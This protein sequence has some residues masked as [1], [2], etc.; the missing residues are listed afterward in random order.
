MQPAMVVEGDPIDHFVL[1]QAPR[2]EA[3]T[4]EALDLQRAK[5]RL[6]HRNDWP[7]PAATQVSGPC[8]EPIAGARR[9][10]SA[11]HVRFAEKMLLYL[12]EAFASDS[13][14]VQNR[15]AMALRQ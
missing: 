4:V 15:R 6:G 1:G 8:S 10:F 14:G 5:Q 12:S 13:N 3:H 2:V 11:G 9:F 7:V